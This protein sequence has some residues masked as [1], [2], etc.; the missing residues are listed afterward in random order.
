MFNRIVATAAGA[1]IV[2]GLL[3][4][5]VQHLQVTQ[6]IR[7]AETYEAAAQAAPA[8]A[9]SH[10]HAD[11]HEHEHAAAHEHEHAAAAA[12]EHG[13]EE[14]HHGGWE[15]APGG[16]RLF[17]T[18]LANISMAVGYA[19]L[20]AAALTLRG[21]PVDW[22]AGVLW[23]GAAYLVFFVAPSLGLPP[24]LPGT[25]AAPVV[26]RQSWWIATAGATAV[27]LGLLVW[28]RHWALKLAALA[29]LA[30]P[31]LVGAPQPAVH[32]GVAPAAL[33]REF[34]VA[35]AVANAAFW[36]ALGALTGWLHARL[37]RTN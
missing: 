15:P 34:I 12:H 37:D 28:G 30:V 18:V 36:L 35:S 14:H 26:A 2:A 33:A 11:A 25:Q 16:E 8:A 32:G 22:R 7:T 9:A 5:G 4:T 3:L 29:L 13:G 17:Y 20:L 6:L 23:G 21:K 31:H 24:E 1:G 10:E 19:L 27:A